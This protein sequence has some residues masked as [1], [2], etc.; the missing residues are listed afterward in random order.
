[1]QTRCMHE[2]PMVESKAIV[3]AFQRLSLKEEGREVEAGG[4]DNT[5]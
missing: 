2:G 5:F 1:M 3:E 4:D